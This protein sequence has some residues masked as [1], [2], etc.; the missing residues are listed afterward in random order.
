VLLTPDRQEWK[1]S[2]A[3]ALCLLL[4]ALI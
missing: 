3:G 2:L 4:T 1:A